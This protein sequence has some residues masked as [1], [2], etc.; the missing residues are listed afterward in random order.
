MPVINPNTETDLFQRLTNLEA[1]VFPA[2]INNGLPVTVYSGAADAITIPGTAILARSGAVDA[3]TLAAPVALQDDGK[4]LRI[5]NGTTQANTVTT[6]SG[7]I[8]DG[9]SSAKDKI[10]FAA[11]AGG[12]I[13]LFAYAGYWYV[14]DTPLNAT[15][16][17]V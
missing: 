5:F 7:K 2:G 13:T 1:A 8:L 17:A 4:M 6:P 9:T 16:S 12:C 10:T 11:Y 15:L 3:A 14:I